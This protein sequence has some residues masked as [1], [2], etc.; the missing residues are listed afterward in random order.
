[1]MRRSLAAALLLILLGCSGSG[2]R[3]PVPEV[4]E[5]WKTSAA[6]RAER[7]AYDGAPPVIPHEPLGTACTI[8]HNSDGIFVAEIGYAPA[9]PH[10]L[11]PG[12]SLE[13]RCQQ[14]HVFQRTRETF[15]DSRFEGV[16]RVSELGA[17]MYAGAPPT[18]PHGLFMREDCVSCH[19]GPGAREG[20]R[21]THPERTRCGQCHAQSEVKGDFAR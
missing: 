21:T 5:A 14:C 9:S 13:S 2:Q 18:M 19:A 4:E 10:A 7:R 3:V 8:C 1:M 12:L 20:I 11:T 16:K 6:G 17:R 15:A